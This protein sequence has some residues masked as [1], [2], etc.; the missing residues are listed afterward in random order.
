MLNTEEEGEKVGKSQK[1]S[2]REEEIAFISET[3]VISVAGMAEEPL[4]PRR[5]FELLWVQAEPLKS[6]E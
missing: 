2:T 3:L 5:E 1:E 6:P 4:L